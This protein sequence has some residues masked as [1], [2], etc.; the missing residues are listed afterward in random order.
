[1][2]PLGPVAVDARDQDKT[3]RAAMADFGLAQRRCLFTEYSR[4]ETLLSSRNCPSGQPP[5][6]PLPGQHS[7]RPA[8]R[9]QNRLPAVVV[10]GAGA[11][12]RRRLVLTRVS[13]NVIAFSAT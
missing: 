12:V 9:P 10:D 11:G 8:E 13:E 2:R 6:A 7:R 5:A 3:A 4:W 1:M